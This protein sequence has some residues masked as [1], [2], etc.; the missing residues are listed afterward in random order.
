ML[1]IK[2]KKDDYTELLLLKSV[3]DNKQ[4]F[5]EMFK[6]YYENSAYTNSKGLYQQ[7]T[8]DI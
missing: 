4:N 7:P 1:Y 8:Q 6:T 3:L 2:T 5:V